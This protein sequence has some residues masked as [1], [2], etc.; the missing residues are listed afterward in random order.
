MPSRQYCL[1]KQTVAL[2]EEIGH[3]GF[4]ARL[5]P[6]K[7]FIVF[8]PVHLSEPHILVEVIWGNGAVL[9]FN[10]DLKAVAVEEGADQ[11][12]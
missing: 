3:E 11:T 1:A 4:V 9:M 12:G 7:S 5:I 10:E 8:D 6:E 2:C